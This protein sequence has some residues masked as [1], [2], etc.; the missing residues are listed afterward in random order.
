MSVVW[1]HMMSLDGFI[2]GC[3]DSLDWPFLF[4][5]STSLADE[6]MNRIS[7]ILAGRRWYGLAIERSDG[8]DGIYG[9]DRRGTLCRPQ[10][11]EGAG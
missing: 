5:E 6:T 2:P 8:V 4:A 3:E 10:P 7:A 11:P 9:G 1:H